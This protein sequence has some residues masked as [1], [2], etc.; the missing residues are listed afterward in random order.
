MK[1]IVPNPIKQIHN[2]FYRFDKTTSGGRLFTVK[3]RK[4]IVIVNKRGFITEGNLN[5]RYN[6]NTSNSLQIVG[7]FNYPI[8]SEKSCVVVLDKQGKICELSETAGN[9]F[10]KGIF[11]E[12]YNKKFKKIMKVKKKLIF[13]GYELYFG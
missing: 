13:L 1:I 9:I 12:K 3:L 4:G 5:L 2:R 10:E 8:N 7:G 6:I 11:L